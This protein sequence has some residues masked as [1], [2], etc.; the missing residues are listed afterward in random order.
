MSYLNHTPHFDLNEVERLVEDLYGWATTAVAL[1]SERDQNFRLTTTDGKQFVLKIAN[2]LESIPFL[3]AQ[4][5]VLQHVAGSVSICPH[6]IL[7]KT[8]QAMETIEGEDGRKHLV[9]LLTYLP[10][11]LMAQV[12]HQS[13]ALRYHLGQSLGHLDNALTDFDHPALHRT[14]HWDLAQALPV[15]REYK[16]HIGDS[17]LLALVEQVTADFEVRVVPLLSQL[18]QSVIHNDANDYNVL[19]GGGQD[20]YNHNQ[21]VVGLI[22]FGD[23]VYTYTVAEVAI[24]A[25]YA[26]LSQ[27]DPLQAAA[28]VVQGYHAAYPLTDVEIETLFSFICMR[29]CVSVCLAAYQQQQRPDDA[30]LG[31]SQTAIRR[32]L[33]QLSHVQPRLARAQL[34]QACGLPPVPQAASIQS[35]LAQQTVTPVLP[36]RPEAVVALDLSVGS[37]LLHGDMKENT[38]VA[39]QTRIQQQMAKAGATVGIGRYLEPRLIYTDDAFASDVPSAAERRTIHLGIDLFAPADTPLFAPLPGIVHTLADNKAPQDYGPVIVLRHETDEGIPFFTL[40]GHL[41]RESLTSLTVGQVVTAGSPIGTI[42]S[43]AVN[44]GWPPHLHFQI[45]TDLLD[46][47]DG[48]PGVCRFSQ[49][50]VW[51]ALALDPN[52]I[53]RLPASACPP[54]PP[55]KAETL[56]QRQQRIGPSLSIGYREPV[57]VVRGWQQY[58]YDETGRQYLDAYNNVPHVGHC[59]PEVVA[60]AQAQMSLL[61]TNTRYLHD[62]LQTYAAKLS[63]TM[64]EPLS[65]CFFVNS[66]SEGNELAL[67]LA[68]TYTGQ[69]DMIV[70]EAAYHGH[71][72][73]LIDISPYKHDGPG[74]QGAP[75]WV[76]TAPIADV[77]RGPYKADD[78]EAGTKYAQAVQAI[79]TPLTRQG[80]G[81]AAFMAESCPSVGGQI[82]FPPGYLA[83]VYEQVR[84]AG[85]ICIADEVQTGYGRIGSHFYAFAEQ[86]VVPDIVV[87]GKPIGNG[88]PISAVVTT[89][90][91]A[92]AFNNG[93]EFFSTFGGNTVSCAVGLA[94][95]QV[96]Q[97]EQL[98]AHAWEVGNYLLAGLRPLLDR[99]PLVGD[100]RGSGLFLG[101]ELVKDRETLTPAAAEASFV[102]NQ[103]RQRG[104]LLGTDGPY[105][106]VIKI[107]P[108]MPFTKHNADF[109]VEMLAEVLALV[110]WNQ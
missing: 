88:H 80:R 5:A 99:Y 75:D 71:T 86:G 42:G 76:H 40:Y 23:M 103:M 2:A 22:D 7:T 97:Q 107:R 49:Q 32:V 52:L 41:S 57:K 1:P 102:A 85:G 46:Y 89:P 67:R 29:L 26:M 87:L 70:L 27:P 45:I 39:V 61:N 3:T 90:A 59:H 100:V 77:Y 81:L 83:A 51:Q 68:R 64:P 13:A 109:L 16:T 72:S 54:L 43:T 17:A 31:V 6:V 36:F 4:T 48:F 65:V 44:G 82:I 96:V 92:A 53:L 37:P 20:L 47:K 15:V 18:R 38:A 108:P 62:L 56:Q 11:Q 60:A 94:V 30:Y 9:R 21:Q 105:H 84:A 10:G 95:L 50:A 8:G 93:M 55:A 104:I 66:A 106:N 73:N 28:E 69:R 12:K 35:W 74:G 33:P 98:M 58:L 101:V 78:P 79:I 63:A 34:R 25:A 91:I 110:P 19:L 14:F 24:A